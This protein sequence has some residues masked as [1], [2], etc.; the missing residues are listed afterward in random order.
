MAAYKAVQTGPNA[1]SGGVHEGL[2]MCLYLQNVSKEDVYSSYV[3]LPVL[4]IQTIDSESYVYTCPGVS[5][6]AAAILAFVE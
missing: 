2:R 1:Q 4:G 5:N 6:I 3:E